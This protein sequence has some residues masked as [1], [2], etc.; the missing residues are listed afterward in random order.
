MAASEGVI[1]TTINM[2]INMGFATIN[3]ASWI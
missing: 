3:G 1:N 2:A